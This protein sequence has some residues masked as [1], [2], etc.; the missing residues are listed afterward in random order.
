MDFGN[1]C[2]SPT[3]FLLFIS[4][5]SS[6]NQ[7]LSVV[8]DKVCH[9]FHQSENMDQETYKVLEKELEN[10]NLLLDPE[11]ELLEDDTNTKWPLYTKVLIMKAMDPKKFH[12][13]IVTGFDELCQVDEKRKGYYQAR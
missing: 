4:Y 9:T 1:A 13:E 6:E 12:E 11:M 8:A 7:S 10:C 2:S 3:D 5:F